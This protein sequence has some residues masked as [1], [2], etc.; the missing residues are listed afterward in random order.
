M[1]VDNMEVCS[2]GY[3]LAKQQSTGLAMSALW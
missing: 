3:Y 2:M 1:V